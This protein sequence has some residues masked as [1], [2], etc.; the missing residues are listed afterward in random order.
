MHLSLTLKKK[1]PEDKGR[2]DRKTI[3]RVTSSCREKADYSRIITSVIDRLFSNYSGSVSTNWSTQS[4]CPAQLETGW[5][6]SV[7]RET[8]RLVTLFSTLAS[9]LPHNYQFVLLERSASR[10]QRVRMTI[11]AVDFTGVPCHLAAAART[12]KL[13]AADNTDD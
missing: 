4:W 11:F 5:Y 7:C 1:F 10:F 8:V 13:N 12:T 9:F 2:S 3:P 6:S